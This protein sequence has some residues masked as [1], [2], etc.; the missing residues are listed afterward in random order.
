MYDI[1]FWGLHQIEGIRGRSYQ[2]LENA[3]EMILIVC[4]YQV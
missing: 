3:H 2:D 4:Y 1:Q